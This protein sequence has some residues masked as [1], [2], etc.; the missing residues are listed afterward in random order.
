MWQ[1][2]FYSAWN[3]LTSFLTEKGGPHSTTLTHTLAQGDADFILAGPVLLD[4]V[5]KMS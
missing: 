4:Q 2:L 3:P 1:T 5:Q